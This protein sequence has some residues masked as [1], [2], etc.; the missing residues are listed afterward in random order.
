VVGHECDPTAQARELTESTPP[1]VVSVRLTVH[2]VFLNGFAD[3]R[4]G[5]LAPDVAFLTRE[6][7][8]AWWETLGQGELL[9]V[10]AERHGALAALAPL[11]ANDGVV[12][13]IG[14]GSSDYLDVLGDPNALDVLLE[15]AASATPGFRGLRLEAL[16][17]GSPTVAALPASA[18]RLGLAPI[19]ERAQPAPTLS[20]SGFLDASRRKSLIRHERALARTGALTVEHI[21]GA[22]LRH[23]DLEPFFE[24]HVTRWQPTPH[25]S[26]FLERAQRRFYERLAA[27][28]APWLRFTRVTWEDRPV[29]FHFGV[30]FA[31]TYLWYKPSFDIELARRSPGEVLLR[32]LLLA[33]W[34]EDAHTFDFGLGDEPFK[35]RFATETPWVRTWGL[36]PA[37]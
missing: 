20:R 15:A 23:L 17:D 7:Q 27:S 25:P 5:E 24:Q 14:G 32:H 18:E 29:A 12:S 16:R 37:S 3:G 22:D 8:Q 4:W 33:A 30:S 6:W 1:R 31:G 11:Y 10:G 26:L 35:Y 28:G 19:Q 13:F 2:P 36:Y 34:D 9:L 21:R